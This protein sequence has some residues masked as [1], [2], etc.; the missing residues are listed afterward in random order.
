MSH[1]SRRERNFSSIFS[2]CHNTA[3]LMG[4]ILRVAYCHHP[5]FYHMITMIRL[6]SFSL[7]LLAAVGRVE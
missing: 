4:F 5:S 7:E 6:V 2:Q 3:G 1:I